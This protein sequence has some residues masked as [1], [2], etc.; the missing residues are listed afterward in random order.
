MLSAAAQTRLLVVGMVVDPDVLAI[1]EHRRTVGLPTIYEISDDFQDF[2]ENTELGGYYGRQ[3]VQDF[4]RRIAMTCDAV[5]YSSPFLEQKYAALSSRRVVFM[6]EAW[7]VGELQPR[8][9]GGRRRVGWT[10]SAGHLDD[11]KELSILMSTACQGS[12]DGAGV[13]W[14]RE[15]DFSLMTTPRNAAFFRERGVAFTRTPTGSWE[16]YLCFVEELEVG[17]AMLGT[18]DFAQGRSD[19]KYIEYAMRGVAAL[20]PRSGTFAHTIR[21]GDNGLLYGSQEEFVHGLRSLVLDEEFLSRIRQGAHRDLVENRNHAAGAKRRLEFYR[22]LVE[23][24]SQSAWAES[25]S[26]LTGCQATVEVIDP[27]EE[28]LT[29][30]MREH[31]T[32]PTGRTLQHYQVLAQQYPRSYRVWERFAA[33][34]VQLGLTEHRTMLQAEAR[35]RREDALSAAFRRSVAA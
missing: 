20:C 25:R 4:I 32:N 31:N 9:M 6:N 33:L 10:A 5:Q 16:D 26:P 30:L 3:D 29:R 14:F 1:V 12:A 34:Y 21:H 24:T 23:D 18:T 8:I 13:D 15:V 7:E 19:G 11:A 27:I 35:R 28:E 17:L 2:P 22:A